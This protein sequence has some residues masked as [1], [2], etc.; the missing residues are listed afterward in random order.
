MNPHIDASRACSAD[1]FFES[2]QFASSSTAAAH[3]LMPM[4][5]RSPAYRVGP[6]RVT[7]TG[8]QH[9]GFCIVDGVAVDERC[10]CHMMC[11]GLPKVGK[12]TSVLTGAHRILH[13]GRHSGRRV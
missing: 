12:L 11:L 9:T 2:S 3:A 6:L 8:A 7:N 13:R 4:P 1:S 10:P 5:A